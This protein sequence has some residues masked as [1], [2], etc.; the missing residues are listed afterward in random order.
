MRLMSADVSNLPPGSRV[1]V[2]WRL[3]HP[4]PTS[5]ATLTDSVG[6][7]TGTDATHLEVLTSRGPVRIE[8]ARVVAAKE[9]PPKPSR[10]G[11]AHL[12]TSVED[13][14]RAAVPSWG[15]LEREDLGDWVLRASRGFTQRG[16]STVP[17][18]SPGLPLTTAVERVE[19]WYAARQLPAKFALAGPVGFAA[20][21]DPLGALLLGRGYTVGSLTLVLTASTA[22]VAAA[23][24]GGPAVAI[25]PVPGEAWLQAYQGTRDSD[26][27]TARGVLTGSPRQLFGSVAPGGG[28]SQQLGVRAPDAAGTAPIALAR[29]GFGA[30]WAGLG[31]VWTDPAFRGRGLAAHLTARLADAALREG[32][33]L[34]HLQVEH[35]NATAIRLYERL[36]FARHSSYAYLTAPAESG[37]R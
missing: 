23:D 6:T 22:T 4:D 8:R 25:E 36:G 9:V 20:A 35:D 11:A 29:L 37:S 30:G 21:D 24:P 2:R 5:G 15:A 34:V 17:V 13:L 16:N 32:V 3:E 33:S 1:V 28:L 27:E 19:Q 18:G 7:L 26:P 14:Q 12:A 31:A 10:R